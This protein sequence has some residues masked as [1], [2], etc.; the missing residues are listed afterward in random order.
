MLGPEFWKKYFLVY[1]VLN[2]SPA[3]QDLLQDIVTETAPKTGEYI[4]DAGGGT[5]NLAV[6]L[7]KT[8]ARV[9]LLDFSKEAIEI[10]KGKDSSAETALADL[11]ER[12]PFPDCTF[13]K[14]VSNNAIY[15]LPR[16]K[17]LDA[18]NE[19]NR[20]LKHRGRIVISNVHKQYKPIVIYIN[21]IKKAYE[22]SGLLS[23]L[24]LL[25]QMSVP[26]AKMFF[27][28]GKIQHQHKIKESNLFSQGEQ[29]ELLSKAG[30]K[31]TTQVEQQ[32]FEGQAFMVAGV[33]N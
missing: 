5:G 6:R 13:D 17:R 28:N 7:K 32:T 4:L 20:V 27:Y 23:T 18:L 19:L 21:T 30:F 11:T 14:V 12:L 29:M 1:D 8:G 3:Y 22:R 24:K 9:M 26:T 2:H 33:K 15:N 10:Y 25:L 16:A 31:C